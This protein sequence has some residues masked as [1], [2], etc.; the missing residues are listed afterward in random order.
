MRIKED[1]V[2]EKYNSL[3]NLDDFIR[4]YLPLTPE[5]HKNWRQISDL[6]LARSDRWRQY[7]SNR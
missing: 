1:K 7:V 4:R 6:F 2:F 3:N 5:E